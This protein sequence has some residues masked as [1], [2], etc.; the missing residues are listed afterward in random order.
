MDGQQPQQPKLS[1][2][3]THETFHN[4]YYP[5]G[6]NHLLRKMEST[7]EAISR[8]RERVQHYL[9]ALVRK[10]AKEKHS[11]ATRVRTEGNECTAR[12]SHRLDEA[13]EQGSS[14]GRI[15]NQSDS[16]KKYMR[17]ESRRL[18]EKPSPD[19]Y[20]INQQIINLLLDS[21]EQEKKSNRIFRKQLKAKQQLLAQLR[22]G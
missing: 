11:V 2:Q 8:S 15:R 6:V 7:K 16:L 19:R 14:T 13:I 1:E 3:S 18:R 12:R 5:T 21:I 4:E 9:Q 20:L 22:L 10:P 17:E